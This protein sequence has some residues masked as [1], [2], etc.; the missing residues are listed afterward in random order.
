M[1][2]LNE[3]GTGYRSSVLDES[4]WT[5]PNVPIISSDLVLVSLFNHNSQY[6]IDPCHA[7][8]YWVKALFVDI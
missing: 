2:P 1:S 8:G 7:I 3:D 6:Q 5:L 4:S